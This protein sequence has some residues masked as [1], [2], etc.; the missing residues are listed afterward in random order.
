[1]TAALGLGIRLA[2]ASSRSRA[3]AMILAGLVVTSVLCFLIGFSIASIDPNLQLVRDKVQ[4]LI[5]VSLVV[6]VPL[7]ILLSTASRLSAGTRDRRLASLRLLGLTPLRTRLV[8]ATES[9]V[10]TLVGALIGLLVFGLTAP[11]VEAAVRAR[12][13]WLRRP[14][15]VPLWLQVALAVALVA[16]TAVVAVLP[17]RAAIR[18]PLAERRGAVRRP[19]IARL[20]PVM[21]GVALL[22]GIVL[23]PAAEDGG[24]AGM[25]A[26]LVFAAAAALTGLG[27]PLAI[28]VLVRLVADGLARTSRRAGLLLAARRLQYEPSSTSRVVAGLVA[29]L[30]VVAGGRCVLGAWEATPQYVEAVKATSQPEILPVSSMSG[31][32]RPTAA[33]GIQAVPG[34]R[35]IA[36]LSILH[37]KGCLNGTTGCIEAIVGTCA[38][39]RVL[40]QGLTGCAESRPA[41]VIPAAKKTAR[42][43]L[44]PRFGRPIVVPASADV[45]RGT[46]RNDLWPSSGQPVLFVPQAIAKL[47]FAEQVYVELPPGTRSAFVQAL[48]AGAV[49][50]DSSHA[51]YEGEIAMVAGYRAMVWAVGGAA[52]AIGLLALLIGAFDRLLERRRQIASLRAVGVP[53]GTLRAGQVGQMVLPLLLGIPLAGALGLLAGAGYL[54]FGGAIDYLPWRSVALLTLA[55]LGLALL[56]GAITLPAIATKITPESLRRE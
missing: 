41:W 28:P 32:P 18:Q 55:G 29:A 54:A 6:V 39:L 16:V 34:A 21:A 56:A 5:V 1:M 31:D 47:A 12:A 42:Y 27:L 9:A 3:L 46:L 25:G 53:V 14:V 52:L 10:L 22:T 33:K 11:L 20:I 37:Q 4:L 19:S 49:L 44:E 26:F 48:P 15:G 35:V 51:M 2:W 30:F 23:D 38:D 50:T 45:L 7:L 36:E 17:A 8:S 13:D 43:Q 24:D 40:V